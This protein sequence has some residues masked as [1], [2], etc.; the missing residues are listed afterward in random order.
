MRADLWNGLNYIHVRI[1]H[2]DAAPRFVCDL[3]CYL[4]GGI[5]IRQF[6]NDDAALSRECSAVRD[7]DDD[8]GRLLIH[9]GARQPGD[10]N[11][12]NSLA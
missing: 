4:F 2:G 7:M 8:R 9:R 11:H 10:A 12:S 3:L 6:E 5:F 1:P